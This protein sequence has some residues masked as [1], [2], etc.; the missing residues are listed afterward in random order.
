MQANQQ[1]AQKCKLQIQPFTIT[2]L[3]NL[4]DE[5]E[6]YYKDEMLLDYE[7]TKSLTQLT[8]LKF[9]KNFE[10]RL[11]QATEEINTMFLKAVEYVLSSDDELN[12]FNINPKFFPQLKESWIKH[13]PTETYASRLDIGFSMDGRDIKLYEFNS[14]CCG[15]VFETSTFQ[16]RMYRHFVNSEGLNPGREMKEKIIKRWSSIIQKYKNKKI[17]FVVDKPIEERCIIFCIMTIL[18]Q[19]GIESKMYVEGE[20]LEVRDGCVYDGDDRVDIIYKTFSWN[21]IYRN[22]DEKYKWVEILTAPNVDVIEP[23]WRTLIGNKALL[24]IVYKMFPDNQWLLPT[25][26]DPFDK[27]FENEEELIEKS[28]LSSGSFGVNILNKKDIKE[29]KSGCIYQKMFEVKSDG[30]YFVLGSWLIGN[31]YAGLILKNSKGRISTY[32]APTTFSRIVDAI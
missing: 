29:T 11:R 3:M 22:I 20:G 31:E 24:P 13:P 21:K 15:Y 7:H 16:D 9:S 19:A 28:V 32:D 8:Y 5:Y 4:E 30:E 25:T 27:V 26:Y 10:D 6:Q 23:M 1:H 14:G 12:K 2:E 17:Y 18:K